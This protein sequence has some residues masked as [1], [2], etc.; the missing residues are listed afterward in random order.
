MAPKKSVKAGRAT[1]AG[2]AVKRMTRANVLLNSYSAKSKAASK[3]QDPPP[4]FYACSWTLPMIQAYARFYFGSADELTRFNKLPNKPEK[5]RVVEAHLNAVDK[6]SKFTSQHDL[7]E[8]I[9]LLTE[10]QQ[11]HPLGGRLEGVQAVEPVP[12]NNSD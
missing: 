7:N 11:E 5:V 1:D 9:K 2:A 8:A 12:A 6:K 4:H 10:R 3:E